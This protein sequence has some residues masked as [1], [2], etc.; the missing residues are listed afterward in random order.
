MAS[1]GTVADP[2][3][4]TRFKPHESRQGVII[5]GKMRV[6]NQAVLEAGDLTLRT[7]ESFQMT[8]YAHKDAVGGLSGMVGSVNTPGSLMNSVQINSYKGTQ[9]PVTGTTHVGTIA[10]GTQQISFTVLGR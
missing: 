10:G 3:I 1:S 6:K 4:F 8:Q 2:T 9:N 5:M 7:I